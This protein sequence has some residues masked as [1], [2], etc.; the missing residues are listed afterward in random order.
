MKQIKRLACILLLAAML[1]NFTACRKN[2]GDG[3]SYF[4]ESVPND[5]S[6]VDPATES[7][8]EADT[9]SADA[10]QN[11]S[12]VESNTTNATRTTNL[13][14]DQVIAQMP[15]KLKNTTIKMMS[16]DD[17]RLG[18]WGSAIK[19][20]EKKT[21]I[22][23]DVEVVNTQEVVT[24]LAARIASGDSPDL[25][26]IVEAWPSVCKNLQP[27][28]NLNY[29]FNDKA[30]DWDIMK[31]YTYNGKT[32]SMQ[33]KNTPFTPVSLIF[34]NK[35]ALK[36]ADMQDMDPYTI[37]KNNPSDWTWDKFFSLCKTF[38][39]RNNNA[40]GYYGGAFGSFY[41]AYI[42]A[43]GLQNVY[44]DSNSGVYINGLKNS[45]YVKRWG[46]LSDALHK[47]YISNT[48]TTTDFEMGK[49]LFTWDWPINL[50]SGNTYYS[51]LK[52][53]NN[54]GVVPIPTDSTKQ[55]LYW[56]Y[57][58]GVPVGAKNPDA[59]PYFIRY[60]QDR[61]SYDI[62]TFYNVEHATEVVEWSVQ[63]GMNNKNFFA[64]QGIYNYL[65]SEEM[66]KATTGQI[67]SIC[68]KYAPEME[69]K[70]KELNESAAALK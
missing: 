35:S 61:R 26:N 16:G 66:L 41:E 2:T 49:A 63:Q 17:I 11:N 64:G 56:Q 62:D 44:Y 19:E 27:L 59:V 30:W 12:R 15:N 18:V 39:D 70:V 29:N 8:S 32:Y 36:K 51:N 6:I 4:D 58:H 10:S 53:G 48:A 38:L 23:L 50:Q 1:F 67:K 14:R 69:K 68:D 25:V 33:V 20:F 43:F 65:F 52:K 9:P 55:V 7:S 34:Y 60:I 45:E 13:T 28:S 54:L 3:S 40:Q 5:I 24:T 57:G 46:I 22:K 47:N 31:D 21:G 42:K 37:W